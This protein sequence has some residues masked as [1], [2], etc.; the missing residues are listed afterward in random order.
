MSLRASPLLIVCAC[1]RAC[2]CVCVCLC[3][4]GVTFEFRSTVSGFS[5][6]LF[7]YRCSIFRMTVI[8][9]NIKLF[10]EGTIKLHILI[11]II[12]SQR[13]NFVGLLGN[14]DAFVAQCIRTYEISNAETLCCLNGINWSHHCH[15]FDHLLQANLLAAIANARPHNHLCL[16][17]SCFVRDRVVILRCCALLKARP[18]CFDMRLTS[19]LLFAPV[20]FIESICRCQ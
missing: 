11:T 7:F 2:M 19:F 9:E 15:H 18:S 4:A 13:T 20:F 5:S 6:L 16:A 14:L 8:Q 17:T 3:V 1:A 12:I 10:F